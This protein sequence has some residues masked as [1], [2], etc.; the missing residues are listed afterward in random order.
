MVFIS[1]IQTDFLFLIS[2]HREESSDV[3]ERSHKRRDKEE[4]KVSLLNLAGLLNK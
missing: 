3:S 4:K 1:G 2:D